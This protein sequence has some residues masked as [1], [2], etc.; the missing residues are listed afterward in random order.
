MGD[1]LRNAAH[2]L[3]E[4]R[5]SLSLRV[6]LTLWILFVATLIYLSLAAVVLLYHRAAI[7][8]Y[9]D[10]KVERAGQDIFASLAA[11]GFRTD[12]GQLERFASDEKLTDPHF[13]SLFHDASG[14]I[15]GTGAPELQLDAVRGWLGGAE[16]RTLLVAAAQAPTPDEESTHTRLFLRRS[17]EGGNSG[18]ILV[19]GVTD[20]HAERMLSVVASVLIVTIPAGVVAAALSGWLF[21]GVVV[22]PFSHLGDL[23][24]SM[25]PERLD[26]PM[27]IRSPVREIAELERKLE[28]VRERLRSALVAQERFISNVSHELKTPVSILLAEAQTVERDGMSESHARF[29]DSVAD[30]M[31]RLGR[32]VESFLTLTRVRAGKGVTNVEL[33]DLNEVVMQSAEACK[34]MA[35]QH[36]AALVPHL[37]A[38]GAMIEG[39]C[40]LLRIMFDNLL[41]NAIRFGP[42]DGRVVIRVSQD[43]TTRVVTVQD[44]GP[45]IPPELVGALFDRFTQE[46]SEP[47]RGRGFGLGLSIAQGVAELHGGV[48]SCRN[49]PGGGCEFMVTL[50]A[51]QRGT[52][53]SADK[54]AAC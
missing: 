39:N 31:R 34:A 26:Q 17:A 16:A 9:F 14:L 45:G 10:M 48:I 37:D 47:S 38:D 27:D 21:G 25:E 20:I 54:A 29:I 40:D 32:M 53:A 33:C 13:V 44:A 1:R 28:H 50:P 42:E 35:R 12:R 5:Q 3:G 2:R 15:A 11:A 46:P 30:E 41:R 6:K 36:G 4:A 52:V 23:A 7:G 19:L 18:Y 22:R 49:L 51:E 8:R 43:A 24:R